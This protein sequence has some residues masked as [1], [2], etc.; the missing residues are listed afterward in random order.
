MRND[1]RDLKELGSDFL[2]PGLEILGGKVEK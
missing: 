2:V 1:E